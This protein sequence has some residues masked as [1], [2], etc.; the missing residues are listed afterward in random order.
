MKYYLFDGN[1]SLAGQL[2]GW[3]GMLTSIVTLALAIPLTGW[4]ATKIGKKKTF[5][6]DFAV[7]CGIRLKMDRI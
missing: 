3:F 4:V 2:Q 6:N 5:Y 7:S 1:D